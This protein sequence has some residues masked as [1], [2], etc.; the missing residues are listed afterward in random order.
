VEL[1]TEEAPEP[2]APGGLEFAFDRA[3]PAAAPTPM[4]PEPEV[5]LASSDRGPEQAFVLRTVLDDP[6]VDRFKI[7]WPPGSFGTHDLGPQPE[8][9][10][11]TAAPRRRGIDLSPHVP[12]YAIFLQ[13]GLLPFV[14]PGTSD[15]LATSVVP[16]DVGRA[17]YERTLRRLDEGRRLPPGHE[18]RTEEFLAAVDFGFPEPKSQAL[19]LVA[20]GG[21]S[22]FRGPSVKLLQFGV[23]AR[24]VP[25]DR[26][27][28]NVTVAVDVSES[29]ASEGRLETVRRALDRLVGEFGPEDRVSLVAFSGTA[30]L[31]AEGLPGDAH[32]ALREA[33]GQLHTGQSTDLA[34]GLRD[35]YAAAQ[36][37][38]WITDMAGQVVL[39]TDD[40]APLEPA[41]VDPIAAHLA[42]VARRG[43]R[44]N[45]VGLG[46]PPEPGDR[47]DSILPTL[48]AAG[49]GRVHWAGDL[50]Q[51]HWALLEALT[52]RP[53]VVATNVRLAVRF[54]PE[55]VAAYRLVGHEP[56][57]F[58]ERLEFHP[59]ADFHAGQSATALYE[60]VLAGGSEGRVAEAVLTWADPATG[61]TRRATRVIR[62]GQISKD[63]V[64]APL[65]VQ[66]AAVVAEAADVL[67]ETP[68]LVPAPVSLPA[69][70]GGNAVQAWL[71]VPRPRPERPLAAVLYVAGQLDSR[72]QQ[73]ASFVE[74]LGTIE[75]ASEANPRRGG[76]R[77]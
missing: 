18:L 46:P 14:A 50:D 47:A 1:A 26:R 12:G 24:E 36:R 33:I 68:E 69:P 61:K 7:E 62:R 57:P 54:F 67:R 29:M 37:A 65:S 63:P 73:N 19:G 72:L 23:Q 77:N 76:G 38:G 49:G 30:V 75:R 10:G 8:L 74:V 17:S 51:V 15:E 41:A 52:G 35:A 40:V 2:L 3:A 66:E 56:G 25:R 13:H 53:Q 20:A 4:S 9:F 5:E 16:L 64:E 59:E 71:N 48:A 70:P 6:F 55:S 28:V 58:D 27:P 11:P 60:V 42:E 31:L 34:A 39:L 22:P 44:L 32:E 43:V 21:T 45:V